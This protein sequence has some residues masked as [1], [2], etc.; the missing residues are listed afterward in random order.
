MIQFLEEQD[1]K[2]LKA[3]AEKLRRKK[4]SKSKRIRERRSVVDHATDACQRERTSR[5][6]SWSR[7]NA[8]ALIDRP[9]FSWLVLSVASTLARHL[10]FLQSNAFTVI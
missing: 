3:D 8:I 1:H 2:K 6:L 5:S 10:T 9:I 4:Q 7:F